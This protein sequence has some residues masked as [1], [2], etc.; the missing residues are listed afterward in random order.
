VHPQAKGGKLDMHIHDERGLI[1]LQ[2]PKAAAAVQAR[3]LSRPWARW[4][5]G[6]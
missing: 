1:A 4:G 2:G 3:A 6:N 5:G